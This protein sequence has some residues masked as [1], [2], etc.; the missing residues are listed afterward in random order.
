MF[1]SIV[2]TSTAAAISAGVL[3]TT[4]ANTAGVAI[5]RGLKVTGGT[6]PAGTYIAS[7]AG[8]G[9]GT[10][11]W[12]LANDSNAAIPDNGSFDLTVVAVDGG[13]RLPLTAI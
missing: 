10:H 5:T 6:V 9:S 3:T 13:A 11:L 2:A 1:D 12:N 4:D 8:T 7:A